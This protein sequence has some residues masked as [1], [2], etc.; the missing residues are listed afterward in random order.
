VDDDV[1]RRRK[2]NE[3]GKIIMW[4]EFLITVKE[5]KIFVH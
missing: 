5:R 2:A 1:G 4:G 3:N